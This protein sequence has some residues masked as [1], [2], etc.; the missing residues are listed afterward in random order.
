MLSD[1]LLSNGNVMSTATM[2]TTKL[3][4]YGAV[5]KKS[6][7]RRKECNL[8]SVSLKLGQRS[9]HEKNMSLILTVN[10]Y[11]W[12]VKNFEKKVVVE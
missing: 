7:E 3:K 5:G 10:E 9:V 12:R 11:K 2:T 8:L 6:R 1:L 4:G